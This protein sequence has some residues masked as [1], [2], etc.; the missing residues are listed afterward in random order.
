MIHWYAVRCE[1]PCIEP[2]TSCNN[3]EEAVR[4][5]LADYCDQ[6]EFGNVLT[7]EAGNIVALALYAGTKLI[8]VTSG[9]EVIRP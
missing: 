5:M 6:P 1:P 2:V 3:L 4:E 8:V 9:G 7:D